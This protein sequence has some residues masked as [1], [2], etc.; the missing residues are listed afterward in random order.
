MK[1]VFVLIS[2]LWICS[3][4]LIDFNHFDRGQYFSDHKDRFISRAL[5]GGIVL[6]FSFKFALILALLYWAVFDAALNKLR[7][8]DYFY[9]GT[10]SET[11]KYF[12]DKP[13]IYKY[14]KYAS[15]IGALLL[16][17]VL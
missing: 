7:G 13:Q 4:A 15:L 8:L 9:L 11:D 5:V 12:A 14:S 17:I 3:Q 10:E 6:M 1:T 2:I 16:L